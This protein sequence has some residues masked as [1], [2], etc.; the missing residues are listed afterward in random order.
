MDM[1]NTIGTCYHVLIFIIFHQKHELY[2]QIYIGGP[3]DQ[4]QTCLFYSR[5]VITGRNISSSVF[6]S[7]N[8]KQKQGIRSMNMINDYTHLKPMLQRQISSITCRLTIIGWTV[9]VSMKIY[10]FMQ[11]LIFCCMYLQTHRLEL[12]RVVKRAIMLS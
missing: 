2:Y 5:M 7:E 11:V 1:I 9:L 3:R 10:H 6:D 8:K 4:A 12:E